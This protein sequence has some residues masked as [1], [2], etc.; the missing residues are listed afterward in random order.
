[1]TENHSGHEN[2]HD[3]ETDS[4]QVNLGL[5]SMRLSGERISVLLPW[6]GWVLV[7]VAMGYAASLVIEKAQIQ[8]K[9]NNEPHVSRVLRNR[10]QRNTGKQLGTADDVDG[11]TVA[12]TVAP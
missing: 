9:K 3:H 6:L 11:G 2:T 7:I 4:L 8:W 1:M 5:F 12:T 10:P